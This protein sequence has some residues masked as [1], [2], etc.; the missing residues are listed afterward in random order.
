MLNE[1][2]KRLGRAK[3][4]VLGFLK[5]RL[6]IPK[7]YIDAEWGGTAVDV[8]AINRDGVGDVH[9][10]L[11]FPNDCSSAQT[12]DSMAAAI[13]SVI[14]RFDQIPAQFKYIGSVDVSPSGGA[15]VPGTQHPVL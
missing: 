12:A 1:E 11:L 3:N 10:V 2:K 9:A 8:L 15:L 5:Q 14:D 7:I 6:S 13:E 4:A